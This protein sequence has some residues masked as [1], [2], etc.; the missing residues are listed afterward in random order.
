MS[1]TQIHVPPKI[2]YNREDGSRDVFVCQEKL[3]HGGFAVVYRVI[4]QNTS[5]TYAMKVISKDGSSSSKGKIF[6]EKLKNEIQIQK[7][8]DHPNIVRSRLSFSDDI[9]YYIILEYCPGKSIREYLRKCEQRHIPEPEA[10][11]ILSDVIQGVVY[12]HNHQIIHHDLKLENFLIGS[13]GR[14]KIADFGISSVLKNDGEKNFSISGTVNYMSPELLQKE[15][16]GHGYE[17]DIWAIGVAAFIMLTGRPPFDGIDKEVVYEK[18]RSGDFRFPTQFSLS[19]EAKDFIKSTLRI[20]PRKRPSAIDLLTHPFLIRIDKEQVQL[21]KSPPKL[22]LNSF[23]LNLSSNVTPQMNPPDRRGS[24]SARSYKDKLGNFSSQISE[25]PLNSIKKS[26]RNSIPTVSTPTRAPSIG[27]N[28][29]SRSYK[30]KISN[31]SSQISDESFNSIKKLNLNANIPVRSAAGNMNLDLDLNLRGVASP[32]RRG[33]SG[34]LSARSLKETNKK[35]SSQISDESFNSIKNLNLN[36]NIPV[37]SPS[38]NLN[39]NLRSISPTVKQTANDG[40]GS[41]SA[42]SYKESNDSSFKPRNVSPP[43]RSQR[44]PAGPRSIGDRGSIMPSYSNYEMVAATPPPKNSQN[45]FTLP[46]YFVAKYCFHKQDLGYLLGNGTVGICFEDRSRII[47]DAKETFIQY[48]KGYNS[49]PELIELDTSVDLVDED[50]ENLKDRIH[51]KFTLVQKFAK[52]L[53]KYQTLF[54]VPLNDPDPSVPLYHVKHFL[55]KDDSIL[56]RLNDKN[57]QV[58]FSDHQKLIIFYNTKKMC[59]VRSLKEKCALL[60]LKNV[61]TMN[62]NSEELKKY[63]TAKELISTLSQ[64]A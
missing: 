18:I 36:A 37:S 29:S 24:F 7:T 15:N 5:K 41:F 20:D 52:S 62:P 12:L 16:K 17:V 14:V 46:S 56:F 1:Q 10:K 40:R 63:K 27:G 39:L 2:V 48:Y 9:N 26:N 47:I 45:Y 54:E 44:P 34:S 43:I 6:L 32:P 23:N 25:E 53:K 50:T 21:Y 13:D 30:D 19:Y 61:I 60:D 42:R 11:K 8:L 58:N 33:R 51:K 31:V 64:K 4:H 35:F 3:G 49:L 59:L 55:K 28:S 57:I 38:S 22:P